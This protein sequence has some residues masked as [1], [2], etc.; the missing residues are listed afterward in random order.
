[1][2]IETIGTKIDEIDVTISSRIIELFSA[3]LYSSP[4]KAFEELICNSYDAFASKVS[5]YAPDDPTVSNA[6][7]WVCDNGE[8]LNREELKRLWRI[9]ESS[10]RKDAKRDGKR[11]QIGQFGIGKLS[12]YILARKLTYI[13]KKEDNALDESGNNIKIIKYTL[14]TMDYNLINDDVNGIKI[15][16]REVSK[17][18]ARQLLEM[19]IKKDLM[20]FEL[21]GDKAEKAWTVSIMTDLKPKASEIKLGRLKWLLSTALPLNPGFEL[22]FNGGNIESSKIKVPVMKKWII[23]K[24]DLTVEKMNDANWREE[25]I[26]SKSKYYVDLPNLKGINGEFILY[27]DSLVEGKSS[28]LGRSHGIFLSIRGRLINL[29]DPLLGMEAFSHGAFNRTR[30]IVNAD[31]LDSNLTSTREAVKDSQPFSQLK[32]YIKKKFNNEVKK[33]Y[34]DQQIQLDKE[35]S[36]ANRMSQTAYTTSKRPVYNFIQNFFDDKIINPIL[37]EKPLKEDKEDLLKSYA[38]DLETGEQVIEVIEYEYRHIE[39][40]I[41]KLKLKARTLTINKSHPYVANYIDSNSNMIPLESMVITEVLTEAHLYELGLD[42]GTVNEIIRRRDSTLRQLALSD[43]MGI[44]AAAMFLKDSLD[45]PNG[46]EEAV[47]R[48]LTV[49]GFEVTPIGGNNEPDGKADAFLGYDEHGKSRSYTLTYDAKSTKKDR[50]AAG[51]AH[52]FGLKRHR[53]KYN[54]DYSL[55][56]AIDYQGAE[57]DD[58]A[59]SIEAKNEQVTMMSARDL[60][61]LLLIITPKQIGLDKL[62]ELFETCHTPKEVHMWI[63]NIEK[64]KVDTPPYYELVDVIYEFQKTDTEAPVIKLVRYEL[65][66]KTGKIYSTDEVREWLTLLSNLI[67]GSVTVEGDYI[68][69]QAS[70]KI[71]KDRIHKA[72]S[73][74]PAEIQPLYNEIFS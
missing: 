4:N 28:E 25:N 49:F 9:G 34:F 52:L 42:E 47:A 26:D 54:A 3:G 68:G 46:L 15:D 31:E 65:N 7:I 41:A 57:Q 29:D 74:I 10:K 17:T 51:T 24:D 11:L 12:T 59:I 50:I 8:G 40:P 48:V 5:V 53:Q 44:P 37:I 32:D 6:Y 63:E 35:K 2:N 62:R 33:Y 39:E 66:K 22:R 13:S 43:K 61:K 45:N 23:G 19:Y 27:E 36:I 38:R 73:D 71:I 70:A 16:E 14:A 55:E 30:I 21:F 67:P 1:M 72:I 18:D 69:V 56:V 58:S 60:I 20:N 64:L